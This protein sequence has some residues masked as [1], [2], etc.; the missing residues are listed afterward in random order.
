LIEMNITHTVENNQPSEIK[1]SML[2]I[3]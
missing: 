2:N 3:N 1:I